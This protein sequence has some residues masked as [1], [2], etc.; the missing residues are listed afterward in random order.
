MSTTQ[1]QHPDSESDPIAAAIA[2]LTTAARGRRTIGAGTPDEHTDPVDFGEIAC[3]V[4][5]A[6]AANVGGVETLLEGRPGS[7]EADYVRQ[8]VLST[9]GEDQAELMRY[10]TE[11]LRIPFAPLWVFE[12]LGLVDLYDE[13]EEELIA[14]EDDADAAVFSAFSMAEER[15]RL[16]AIV[17]EIEAAMSPE[18]GEVGRQRADALNDE[19]GEIAE[20][21]QRRAREAGDPRG[22]TLAEAQAATEKLRTLW[23]E[24][25]T[26]YQE[27]FARAIRQEIAARG[28]PS[29]VEFVAPTAVPGGP[30]EDPLY[31]HALRTAALPMTGQAP[32]WS[33]GT[34]ADALRRAGL[35]Y[36]ARVRNSH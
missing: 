30:D 14:Q 4:I 28:L 25:L 26:R 15:A 6:V 18:H 13:A 24:D 16:D 22:T 20:A 35:T 23:E 21:I 19:I 10:R 36:T 17:P 7:W 3:H 32:D 8:I 33:E 9:A 27:A 31:V 1:D 29:A 5:T 34:P 12:E 2:A 11:P